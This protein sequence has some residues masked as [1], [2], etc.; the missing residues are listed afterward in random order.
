MD[1]HIKKSLIEISNESGNIFI[2]NLFILF[3]FVL[4]AKIKRQSDWILYEDFYLVN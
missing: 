4:L 3:E 1:K 2:I